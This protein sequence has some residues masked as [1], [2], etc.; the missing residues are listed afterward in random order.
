MRS[1]RRQVAGVYQRAALA[2]AMAAVVPL[3]GC[4]EEAP[5]ATPAARPVKI[6]ALGETTGGPPREFPG[7][8][9]A[10][11]NA[12]IG[13]EVAGKLIEFD[14][15]ESQQVKRGQ[16][17]AKL[18]PRDFESALSAAT[19]NALA[20]KADLDRYQKMFEEQVVSAQQLEKAQRGYD[21]T[22]AR[23]ETA[24]KSLEDTLL[25]APFDG[26]VARK[27]A[28]DFANVEAKE[29]VVTLQTGSALEIVVNFPEQD[30]ARIKP[31]ATI[32]ELNEGLKADVVVSA[33]P[34]RK[35]PAKL[36]EFATTA[37]PTTRTFAATFSFDAPSDV[38]IMPGMTAKL[39]GV[40][41]D[42]GGSLYQI[43]VQAAVED[44]GGKP[45]VW[46][47]DPES[48]LVRQVFVTLGELTGSSVQVLSGLESGAWV[49]TSGVHQLR[50][51]MEVRRAGS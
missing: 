45:Y 49:V 7:E 37:D 23:E 6:L 27:I 9:T 12:D 24:A 25:R 16:V 10:A 43:P 34:G 17:L 32:S 2:L 41:R 35:F 38:N 39:I 30:F 15:R 11:Q 21:V 20:S 14:V 40:G 44:E 28:D 8:I 36:K 26:V 1:C 51:G 3:F 46:L 42:R 4:G 13:F 18:D 19:A 33:V 31:G 5:P 29:P 50:E 48:M 22:K 47:V